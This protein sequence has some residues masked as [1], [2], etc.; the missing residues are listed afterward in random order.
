VEVEARLWSANS[1]G[2][3]AVSVVFALGAAVPAIADDRT[4]KDLC[5][6]PPQHAWPTPRLY[7]ELEPR[8]VTGRGEG[9]VRRGLVEAAAA[10]RVADTAEC[11]VL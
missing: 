11:D 6:V 5:E 1:V 8:K 10:A 3:L 2:P 7:L 4:S 9:L